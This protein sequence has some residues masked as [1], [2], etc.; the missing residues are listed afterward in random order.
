MRM[1]GHLPA[2]TSAREFGDYLYAQGIGN[3]IEPARD[4]TWELWVEAEDQ[5]ATA[6]VLLKEYQGNPGDPKYQQSSRIAREKR[7]QEQQ[8]NEAAQKRFFDR[9]NLFPLSWGLGV[10]TGILIAISV[11]TAL[12]SVFGGNSKPILWMFIS[13][14]DVEGGA[15]ARLGGL[16]E[17][18]HGELWRLFT[19]MFIHFG[20]LH[21]LF[22]MV[23]LLDLG[24]MIE[25]R[26]STRV[27]SALVLVIA[28]LSD[29]GQ[30]LWQGPG[31]G[32][33]SGVVYGLIGYIWL[34]GKFDPA[35]GLFLHSSTVTMAVIWFVLCLVRVIPNMANGA[36]GV[37][38]A[39]GIAWG[40][41][42]ALLAARKR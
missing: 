26:Q 12:V 23:W 1:I 8:A 11:A 30:Y 40:Y 39:V 22:N 31:F 5:I 10:T 32:G 41:V 29:F 7:E 27:L 4:G 34:R 36:H 42:S 28:A 2:E 19:P 38:F 3:R 17:I 13:E 37:G 9:R 35:S 33:M 6:T 16:P 21:L 15:M 14:Y 25:R 20:L 18:R 24:T